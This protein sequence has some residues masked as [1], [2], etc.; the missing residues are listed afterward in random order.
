[1]GSFK[2]IQPKGDGLSAQS[3]ITDV[4]FALVKENHMRIFVV[5]DVLQLTAVWRIAQRGRYGSVSSDDK[6]NFPEL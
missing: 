2:D 4:Y 3:Q 6:G 1:M 5:A